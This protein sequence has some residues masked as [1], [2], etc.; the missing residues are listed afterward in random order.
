M[1]FDFFDW[2]PVLLLS[3]LLGDDVNLFLSALSSRLL[4]ALFPYDAFSLFGL[5]LFD[6]GIYKNSIYGGAASLDSGSFFGK[7]FFI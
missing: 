2:E 6:P 5:E 1:D 7:L 4:F 3:S